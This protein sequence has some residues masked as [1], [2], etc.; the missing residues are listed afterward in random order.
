[1]ERLD[2]ERA[3]APLGLQIGAP[4]DPITPEEGEHVV[5]VAALRRLPSDAPTLPPNLGGGVG[6]PSKA[7]HLSARAQRLMGLPEG[8]GGGTR[9]RAT[10]PTD[11]SCSGD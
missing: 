8:G 10:F 2:D 7:S 6:A 9:T 5:A 11:S 1:V 3:V 4:D